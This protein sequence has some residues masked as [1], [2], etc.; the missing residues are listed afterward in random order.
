MKSPTVRGRRCLHIQIEELEFLRTILQCC[1]SDLPRVSFPV[2]IV[3]C[4]LL[5]LSFLWF[6]PQARA[7]SFSVSLFPLGC[8]FVFSSF[9]YFLLF[10]S[11]R[12]SLYLFLLYLFI[13]CSVFPALSL[14]VSF[15]IYLPLCLPFRVSSCPGL[16]S[17]LTLLSRCLP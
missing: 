3:Y 17:F 5:L 6:R 7:V 10:S 11:P 1:M 8:F 15:V 9:Y 14:L 13:S 2:R 4:V 16:I 12:L